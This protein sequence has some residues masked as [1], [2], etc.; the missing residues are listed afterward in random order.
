[1]KNIIEYI[2]EAKEFNLVEYNGSRGLDLYKLEDD[3]KPLLDEK[4]IATL[5]GLD[6]LKNDDTIKKSDIVKV[7]FRRNVGEGNSGHYVEDII[8]QYLRHKS[9]RHKIKFIKNNGGDIIIDGIPF[10]LKATKHEIK[11]V[12]RNGKKYFKIDKGLTCT[13]LQR[14]NHNNPVIIAQYEISEK[15]TNGF[16]IKQIFC[17]YPDELVWGDT[18]ITGIMMRDD[19]GEIIK[20]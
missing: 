19:K 4:F 13:D 6:T 1:M 17:R 15:N 7:S 9:D 5:I 12:T 11:E 16:I 2:Q 20:L 8:G 10:E 14:K 18:T 3:M